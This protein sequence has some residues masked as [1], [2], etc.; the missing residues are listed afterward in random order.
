M[1]KTTSASKKTKQF[2]VKLVDAFIYIYIPTI[3]LLPIGFI[4]SFFISGIIYDVFEVDISSMTYSIYL[5]FSGIFAVLFPL[6][7]F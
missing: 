1:S 6:F 5:V 3:V 7:L 2:F 4:I